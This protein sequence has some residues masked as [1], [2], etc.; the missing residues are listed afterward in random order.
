MDVKAAPDIELH[1]QELV[2]DGFA[3]GDRYAVAE[4]LQRELVRL[5]EE[6]GVPAHLLRGD[7]PAAIDAGQMTIPRGVSPAVVGASAAQAIHR[8][9]E[10]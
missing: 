8:G 1:I 3:P 7:A 2:L 4:G 10:R 6:H 9:L 5:L